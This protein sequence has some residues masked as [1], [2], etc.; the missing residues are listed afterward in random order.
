MV[1]QLKSFNGFTICDRQELQAIKNCLNRFTA[2]KPEVKFTDDNRR[3]WLAE[4]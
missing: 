1:F 3:P 2:H 4:E